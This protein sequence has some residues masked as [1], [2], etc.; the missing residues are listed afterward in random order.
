MRLRN[1]DGTNMVI[2]VKLDQNQLTILGDLKAE[3][4]VKVIEIPR[5]EAE[6]FIGHEC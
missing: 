1:I 5:E 4:T 6:D 2:T 3:K